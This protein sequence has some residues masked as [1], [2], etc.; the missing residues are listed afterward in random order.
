MLVAKEIQYKKEF[1]L[2]ILMGI[3]VST[4]F[5]ILE[6]IVYLVK[7]LHH[8]ELWFPLPSKI[9]ISYALPGA[10]LAFISWLV[11]YFIS[12]K[13][14]FSLEKLRKIFCLIFFFSFFLLYLYSFSLNRPGGIFSF[15]PD[16]SAPE[17][18]TFPLKIFLLI[19]LSFIGGVVSLLLYKI[20]S[21]LFRIFLFSVLTIFILIMLSLQ[22]IDIN[23]LIFPG[24]SDAYKRDP[25]SAPNVIMITA[26]ALRADHLSFMGG[27]YIRTKNICRCLMC[28]KRAK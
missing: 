26:D 17:D 4:F 23:A 28:N 6:V 22:F 9:W 16:F 8:L 1:I 11:S 10:L 25:N 3:S 18:I 15:L 14:P 13:R 20:I 7:K 24:V 12:K 21:N 5:W 19:F 2:S 27:S